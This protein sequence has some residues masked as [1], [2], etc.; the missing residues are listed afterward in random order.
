MKDAELWFSA[1]IFIV[2]CLNL[3][4]RH[5]AAVK[6]LLCLDICSVGYGSELWP[7]DTVHYSVMT[8]VSVVPTYKMSLEIG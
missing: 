3:G 7:S 4:V 2:K 8:A 1:A 5:W 6:C